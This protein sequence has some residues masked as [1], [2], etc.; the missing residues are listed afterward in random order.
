MENQEGF[1]EMEWLKGKY[2]S[3]YTEQEINS[4]KNFALFW[5]IFESSMCNKEAGVLSIEK[6]VI[7]LFKRDLLRLEDFNEYL[8][9][10]QDRYIEKDE[11][12]ENFIG[13]NFKSR[14]NEVHA[15]IIVTK[16]LKGELQDNNN[17]VQALLFIIY[18]FRNNLFHGEKDIRNLKLQEENFKIAN[19][20][21]AKIIDL[22]KKN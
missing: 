3:N 6:A 8:C 14:G 10:F 15:K 18:R 7:K 4:V 12:N 11:P 21:L 1:N 9:Y 19:R 5:N 16:V 2:F 13:L 22:H 20:L 17:I